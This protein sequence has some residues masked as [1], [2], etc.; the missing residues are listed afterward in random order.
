MKP[1]TE[2]R[3]KTVFQ[4][5]A[6]AGLALICLT[7]LHKGYADVSALAKANPGDGFWSALARHLFRS[8]AGG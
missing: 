8:L 4:V 2:E 3:I 5:L 7:I 6:I 1:A